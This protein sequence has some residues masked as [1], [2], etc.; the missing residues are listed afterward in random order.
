MIARPM[1]IGEWLVT[2]LLTQGHVALPLVYAQG[3]PMRLYQTTDQAKAPQA[4]PARIAPAMAK[5]R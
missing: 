4:M 3:L 5:P 1:Q 2:T